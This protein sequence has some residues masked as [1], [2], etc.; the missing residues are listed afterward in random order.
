MIDVAN[1]TGLCPEHCQVVLVKFAPLLI[2]THLSRI[3]VAN[4]G[5]IGVVSPVGAVGEAHARAAGDGVHLRGKAVCCQGGLLQSVFHVDVLGATAYHACL[6]IVASKLQPVTCPI[7]D[8]PCERPAPAGNS[9]T[10][11]HRPAA[12]RARGGRLS[13]PGQGT[14]HGSRKLYA[15]DVVAV[16]VYQH[17]LVQH[18]RFVESRLP[19]ASL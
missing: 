12:W 7:T 10:A 5:P 6:L 19:R 13:R 4:L 17:D 9:S 15:E 16:Q 14:C 3:T 2:H 8:P 1:H 11:R 18:V